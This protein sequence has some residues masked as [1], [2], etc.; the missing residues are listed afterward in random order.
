MQAKS[1]KKHR[2]LILNWFRARKQ[3]SSGIVE[4]LN[5]RVKV[6]FRKAFGYRTLDAI[7]VS[8]Y[9]ELGDLPVRPGTHRFCG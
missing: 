2:E 4:G 8:L 9:H 7:Q 5:G 3:Y 1:L 6:R